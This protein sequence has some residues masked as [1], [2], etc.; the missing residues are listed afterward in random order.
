MT[1]LYDERYLSVSHSEMQTRADEILKDLQVTDEEARNCEIDTRDQAK[2][3]QWFNF[4][5]GRPTASRMKA[6]CR[7]SLETPSKSLMKDICYPNKKCSSKATDWG[8]EHESKARS[9]YL[10]KMSVTHTNFQIKEVGFFID[11]KHPYIGASPDGIASCDCCGEVI[12][13]IKCPFCKRD[14]V[15]DNSVDC[16]VKIDEKLHLNKN[17]QYYYQV[18]CQLLVTGR[19]YCDFIVWT[20]K[21]LF[22]ERI[23]VDNTVCKEISDKS[24][25]FFRRVILP[26]LI[27]KF[28]SRPLQE[29][30]CTFTAN[31]APNFPQDTDNV[32]LT[33]NKNVICICRKEYDEEKDDVIGCDD[34]NCPFKW[35]HFKCAGIRKIPNGKWLCKNC[36]PKAIK[37]NEH[38][39]LHLIVITKW[40]LKKD[41]KKKKENK[42]CRCLQGDLMSSYRAKQCCVQF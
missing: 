35:L 24:Q 37:K 15:K 6:I 21:D 14:S 26:E 11:T 32:N 34:E 28:Y 27:G 33:E 3:K 23:S 4:R 25:L 30:S 31:R 41:I 13:E 12:I 29:Q 8:C 36:R 22:V 18:Q 7:T 9:E 39:V 2:C 17:H 42:N 1:D 38:L 10:A 5:S 40:I 20:K 16:L 19:E